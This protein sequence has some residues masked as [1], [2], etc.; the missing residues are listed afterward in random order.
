[1]VGKVPLVRPLRIGTSTESVLGSPA[2][3]SDI[4]ERPLAP[5]SRRML[6]VETLLET[7]PGTHL[8]VEERSVVGRRIGAPGAA[9]F[10]AAP[11]SEWPVDDRDT[12][13]AREAC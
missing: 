2:C 11:S 5:V 8:V 12:T 10:S 3:C 7:Y 9:R 13:L 4:A 6:A 1:M